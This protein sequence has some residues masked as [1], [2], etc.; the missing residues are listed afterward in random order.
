[1]Q[2]HWPLTVKLPPRQ[3]SA[4]V[5]AQ[6]L[7]LPLGAGIGSNPDGHVQA[8]LLTVPPSQAMSVGATRSGARVM[9]VRQRPLGGSAYVPDGQTHWPAEFR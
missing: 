2:M 5:R 3:F 4:W 7:P 6:T 8:P 9:S 1:L